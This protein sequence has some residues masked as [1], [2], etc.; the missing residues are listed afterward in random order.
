MAD[1]QYTSRPE[2]LKGLPAA[3]AAMMLPQTSDAAALDPVLT[4]Y[5]EQSRDAEPVRVFIANAAR[6]ARFVTIRS[7]S[8]P[9]GT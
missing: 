1:S 9:A 4:H 6:A 5:R 7:K 3:G 2:L 8:L